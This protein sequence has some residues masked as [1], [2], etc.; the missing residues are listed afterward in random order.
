MRNISMPTTS[1]ALPRSGVR[2]FADVEDAEHFVDL[3]MAIGYDAVMRG[4]GLI[5][6]VFW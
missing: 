4:T 2:T 5:W 1:L 3:L 6:R